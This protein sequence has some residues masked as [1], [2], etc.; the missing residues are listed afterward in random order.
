MQ[1]HPMKEYRRVPLSMLRKRLKVEE[2]EA[3][4]PFEAGEWRPAA[5]RI[6]LRQ[7]AGAPAKPT[8]KEGSRVYAGQAVGRVAEGELGA[9]VH[10]SIDGLVRRDTEEFIDVVA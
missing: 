8:V 1:V 9:T 7:H 3:A 6:K 2:Y 10:A 5:V 4:T